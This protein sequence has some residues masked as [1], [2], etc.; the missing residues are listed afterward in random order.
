MELLGDFPEPGPGKDLL[1]QALDALVRKAGYRGPDEILRNL[2]VGGDL[3]QEPFLE[4]LQ[5]I[6]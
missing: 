4:T 5:G 6:S 3:D 1:G 2:S